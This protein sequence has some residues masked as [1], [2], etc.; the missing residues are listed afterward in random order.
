[1]WPY[2]S[3]TN[4]SLFILPPITEKSSNYSWKW[5]AMMLKTL[6]LWANK[7]CSNWENPSCYWNT[8]CP[9]HLQRTASKEKGANTSCKESQPALPVLNPTV[10]VLRVE[11]LRTFCIPM[12]FYLNMNVHLLFTVW[13]MRKGTLKQQFYIDISNLRLRQ[14]SC[15]YCMPVN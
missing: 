7:P 2:S 3:G 4:H 11:V 8:H 6:L 14:N 9:L 1:M 12:Q 10:L 13:I 15:I 5:P